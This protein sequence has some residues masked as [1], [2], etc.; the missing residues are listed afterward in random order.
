MAVL[1]MLA[2]RPLHGYDLKHTYDHRFPHARPLGFGQVYATLARLV[3]DDLIAIADIGVDAGPERTIYEVTP[4]GERRLR[5]WLETPEPP[6]PYVT[7]TLFVKVVVALLTQGHAA[8][9]LRAQRAAHVARMRE[10]T[11][12]K[13]VP[14]GTVASLLAADYALGHLDADL[15]WI[16][17]TSA[18]L[19][20]LAAEVAA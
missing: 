15:R 13:S 10:L 14:D 2:A 11:A 17:T 12:L 5:V 3:R 18:R 4:E 7:N 19:D 6:V 16:D 8:T 1:G 9:Y 20:E